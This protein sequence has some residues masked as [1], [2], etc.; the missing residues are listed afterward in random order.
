MLDR[1]IKIVTS[2]FNL[3]T[4][5]VAAILRGLLTMMTDERFGGVNEFIAKFRTAGLDR[6]VDSWIGD[7]PNET[8]SPTQTRAA[9]GRAPM[10]EIADTAGIGRG[11]IVPVLAFLV[12]LLVDAI[13]PEGR[14]PTT[15]ELNAR[16]SRFV[17]GEAASRR[18]T[19]AARAGTGSAVGG[20]LVRLAAL[21]IPVL[22]LAGAWFY[23]QT[24]AGIDPILAVSNAGGEVTFTAHVKDEAARATIID[25]LNT[26]FGEVRV[27]GDV[28]VDGGVKEAEWM[29]QVGDLLSALDTPGAELTLTGDSARV[30]GW[31]T[32]E[33]RSSVAARVRGALGANIAV[34]ETEDRR[35]EA[36]RIANARASAALAG[37]DSIE[38]ADVRPERLVSALNLSVIDF[39]DG[40][41]EIPTSARGILGRA[42]RA[43]LHT[44]TGT[45]IVVAGHTDAAGDSAANL[46]LS[47]ERARAVVSALVEEGVEPEMLTVLGYG[48]TRPVDPAATGS[49]R[50]HN[51]RIEYAVAE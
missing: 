46:A 42:A 25:A 26:T 43:L 27:K 12:P 47:E 7:G 19:R 9:L 16:T 4:D 34:S 44:P 37:L 39:A 33:E 22:A 6:L 38:A 45:R 31:L 13:S 48:G 28:S 30:G 23:L 24:G 51:Q 49:A 50:F 21:A 17:H 5:A 15:G 29:P 1:L 18:R 32:E 3:E 14:L 10:N 35:A 11:A 36:L 40:R 2:R 8:L 41:A 20:G